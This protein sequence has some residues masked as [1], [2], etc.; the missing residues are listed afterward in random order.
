MECDEHETCSII[1]YLITITYKAIFDSLCG[2]ALVKD[3][4]SLHYFLNLLGSCMEQRSGLS[5]NLPW[6]NSQTR[7][8]NQCKICKSDNVIP[9]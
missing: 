5:A 3:K 6:S 9:V 2:P 8:H 1:S 7:L 4:Y